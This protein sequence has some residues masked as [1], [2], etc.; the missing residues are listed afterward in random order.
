MLFECAIVVSVVVLLTQTMRTVAGG[1][2]RRAIRA[3]TIRH[4]VTSDLVHK[5]RF[6]HLIAMIGWP[7][8]MRMCTVLALANRTLTLCL[9]KL[10]T[11]TLPQ[12]DA[13]KAL[14]MMEP[15]IFSDMSAHPSTRTVDMHVNSSKHQNCLQIYT[16]VTESK[17][18]FGP[19]WPFRCV[20]AL[21]QQM[22]IFLLLPPLV[23]N[24]RALWP[25]V[26]NMVLKQQVTVFVAAA[27]TVFESLRIFLLVSIYGA[28]AL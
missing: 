14:L 20:G 25:F 5:M 23:Q 1:L 17:P 24:C 16:L 18:L 22:T 10:L 26:Q 9:I 28:S 13:T 19:P 2:G 3:I 4:P 6:S 7:F 21:K 12:T 15:Q 27:T 8:V 11:R